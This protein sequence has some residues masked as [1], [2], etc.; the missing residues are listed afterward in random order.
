VDLDEE[1]GEVRSGLHSIRNLKD[2]YSVR[3][4]EKPTLRRT[5]S[6]GTLQGLSPESCSLDNGYRQPSCMPDTDMAPDLVIKTAPVR[7]ISSPRASNQ[8]ACPVYISTDRTLLP[9]FLWQRYV[10]VPHPTSPR[11][12][13]AYLRLFCG[14]R[15]CCRWLVVFL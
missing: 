6:W 4:P 14:R 12:L 5:T 11:W 1:T 7:D 13:P 9:M 2:Y 10:L 15:A 8:S 3:E